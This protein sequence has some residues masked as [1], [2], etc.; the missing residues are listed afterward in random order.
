MK[1]LI[2]VISFLIPLFTFGQDKASFNSLSNTVWLG[3]SGGV[4][5]YLGDF[6]KSKIEFF[7]RG[8]F[9]Y[10]F[11]S[12]ST[13]LFGIKVNSGYGAFSGENNVP[14][15]IGKPSRYSTRFSNYFFN[16]NIGLVYLLNLGSVYPYLSV[17][18]HSTF[19]YKVLD[20]KKN[21][22]YDKR[23]DV[24]IGF[25][26]E[27][28]LKFKLSEGLTL[29]FAGIF[30]S[31]NTDELDGLV[32]S[33]KDIYLTG[34]VGFSVFLGG[35]KDS[36]KDGV[37]D[38]FDLCLNTPPGI[39]VDEFGCPVKKT[40][41]KDGDGVIDE[42]DQCPDTPR[43]V[44]VNEKGCP[45]DSD[46][47]GVPDYMDRC[48][49]T[50]KDFPVDSKGCP[51]DSDGDGVFDAL[52]KCPNTPANVEVND[53]GCPKDSDNDGVPDN[54]DKCPDTIP[55]TKVD[56]SGCPVE[57]KQI[58]PEEK[59]YILQGMTTFEKGKSNLTESAKVEL[60]K[61]AEIILKYPGSVW[62]IEG[63][64]DSQGSSEFNKK[65]S[66]K[67]ADAVKIY[68]IQ[69]GVPA[70]MLIAEGMGEVYPIADNRTE[71]GRQ[72]NRRVVITKIK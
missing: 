70:T 7:A 19:W 64:T 36:D 60:K 6:S 11:E 28:G 21:E 39:P 26:G 72:K 66:Q 57:E 67:R 4:S 18:G 44:E 32:S 53:V 31:P 17:G 42:F 29:N 68:L 5:Y 47:D 43:G 3:S 23:P 38:K 63:H 8:E 55:V 20:E 54:L 41:D 25:F 46:L 65:L 59:T 69:I 52:D 14:V 49:G 40:N 50:P 58:L 9:E 45:L 10:F 16:G 22:A 24:T 56:S 37:L 48:P 33:K 30:S 35:Q 27:A 61:L 51:L 1:K 62:R 15:L 13:G 2:F 34:L 12:Q 71:E